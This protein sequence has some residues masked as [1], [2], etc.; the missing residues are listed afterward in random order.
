MQRTTQK[1][2]EKMTLERLKRV[3][4]RLRKTNTAEATPTKVKNYDLRRA[5]IMECGTSPITYTRNRKALMI[6]GWIKT[7]NNKWITLTGKDMTD[8]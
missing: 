4:W 2:K 1:K 7:I 3:M 6:L 5:I 8:V